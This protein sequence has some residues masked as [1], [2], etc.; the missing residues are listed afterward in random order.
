[1]NL[2]AIFGRS[3]PAP[4]LTLDEIEAQAK[5]SGF[6]LLREGE[7]LP[8]APMTCAEAG[9]AGYVVRRTQERAKIR[10]TTIA[11]AE[12]IGRPDL[13]EPLR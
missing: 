4:A 9:A 12:K 5:A 7:T 8:P 3:R 13:A 6:V 10:E 2:R 1:M 11:L